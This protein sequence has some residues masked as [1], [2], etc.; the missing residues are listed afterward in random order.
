M[1]KNVKHQERTLLLRGQVDPRGSG[2]ALWTLTDGRDYRWLPI[3]EHEAQAMGRLLETFSRSEGIAVVWYACG[4]VGPF[5]TIEGAYFLAQ[6]SDI[7]GRREAVWVKWFP[8]SSAFVADLP[9]IWN[10][11]GGVEIYPSVSELDLF[12]VVIPHREMKDESW[13]GDVLEELGDFDE[14]E[15]GG[16]DNFM[17]GTLSALLSETK[18]VWSSMTEEK[19]TDLMNPFRRPEDFA[20]VEKVGT[21]FRKEGGDDTAVLQFMTQGASI[22]ARVQE[23]FLGFGIKVGIGEIR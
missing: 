4:E 10:H 12:R 9:P 17:E 3:D 11:F 7:R 18:K 1:G 19:F 20:L 16:F 15:E 13:C 8:N 22:P 23:I 2:F 5:P 21:F 14:D 6:P